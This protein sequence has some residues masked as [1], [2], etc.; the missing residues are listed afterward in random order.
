MKTDYLTLVNDLER[1]SDE[2]GGSLTPVKDSSSL[3]ITMEPQSK[4]IQ[5]K[6]LLVIQV[7]EYNYGDYICIEFSRTKG[8]YL[9]FMD[10]FL[11]IKEKLSL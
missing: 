3:T 6:N 7:D 1:V 11:L 2:I 4:P 9:S 8:D 5:L 10:Y